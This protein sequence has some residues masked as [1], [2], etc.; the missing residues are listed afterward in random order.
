M[1]FRALVIAGAVAFGGLA[2]S[3]ATA[4]EAAAPAAAIDGVNLNEP[5]EGIGALTRGIGLRLAFTEP[6]PE[7]SAQIYA[8][9]SEFRAGDTHRRIEVSALSSAEQSGLPVD[10][11]VAQRAT[12]RVSEDGDL[13]HAGRGTEVRIGRGLARLANS[14][15][16][17][18][19]WR[20]PTWYLFAAGDNEQLAWAPGAQGRSSVS[21]R[22]DRVE[23]GDMQIGIA[24]EAMGIQAS[25][26]YVQR[27]IHG[28]YGSVDENFTG[29]T[30]TWRR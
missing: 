7:R 8:D 21:Y 1:L 12:L 11:S 17:A 19:S 30:L 16:D 23:I 14:W 3:I 22:E 20:N 10:V 6:A 18:G 13:R 27:D 9:A 2:F 5:N 26:A 28:K 24:A 29:V 15:R 4:E 25:L